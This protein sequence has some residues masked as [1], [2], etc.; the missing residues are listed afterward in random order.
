MI[1]EAEEWDTENDAKTRIQ[2]VLEK[3]PTTKKQ[4]MGIALNSKIG[5]WCC[6]GSGIS[7][8]K[9][10]N[11]FLIS[12]KCRAERTKEGVR[13]TNGMLYVFKKVIVTHNPIEFYEK[14]RKGLKPMQEVLS[15]YDVERKRMRA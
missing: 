7:K 4:L 12:K 10:I 1:V 11:N 8:F 14:S 5:N 6:W 15:D 9:T 2:E 13:K 3:Y